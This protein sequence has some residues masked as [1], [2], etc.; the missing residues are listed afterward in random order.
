MNIDNY[1]LLVNIT[2]YHIIS[3]SIFL[4]IIIPKSMEIRQL[5]FHVKNVCKNVNNQHVLNTY[6]LFDHNYQVI[7]PFYIVSNCI[8]NQN[9]MF[10]IEK[11]K[12]S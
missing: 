12:N 5:F 11:A 2:E 7:M 1:R 4:T 6:R 9:T 3:K 10:K 8:R